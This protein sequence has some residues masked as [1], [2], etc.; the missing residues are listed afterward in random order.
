[1]ICNC[2]GPRVTQNNCCPVEPQQRGPWIVA[3]FISHEGG[4]IDAEE[5]FSRH[6]G[7]VFVAIHDA[8]HGLCHRGGVYEDGR[9]HSSGP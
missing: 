3:D 7:V 9:L 8:N 1:M 2:S 5:V 6:Y 4:R